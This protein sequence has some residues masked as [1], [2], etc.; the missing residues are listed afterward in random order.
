MLYY[1][2]RGLHRHPSE[3]DLTLSELAEVAYIVDLVDEAEGKWREAL[4][5]VTAGRPTL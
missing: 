5:K 2:V 4:L 1:S 3:C